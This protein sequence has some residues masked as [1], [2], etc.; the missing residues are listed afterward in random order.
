M[1]FSTLPSA[2][3][4][5]ASARPGA[6]ATKFSCL[7]MISR[8]GASTTPAACDR[9]DS[10]DEAAASASSIGWSRPIR[11]S[12][13]ARLARVGRGGLHDPVDEQP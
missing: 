3:T 4:R 1:R 11:R 10:A 8:F 13:S 2:P 6:S 9:P 12:I 7:R 5:I